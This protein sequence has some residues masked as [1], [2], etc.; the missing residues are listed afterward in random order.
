MLAGFILEIRHPSM[1]H[2]AWPALVMY[3]P[4]TMQCRNAQE[5]SPTLILFGVNPPFQEFHSH[6]Q[7]PIT[8]PLIVHDGLSVLTLGWA[9][10]HEQAKSTDTWSARRGVEATDSQEKVIPT[11]RRSV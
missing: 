1:G 10:Q 11:R 3:V 8:R 7:G 5:K 4:P 9:G 6:L 2:V